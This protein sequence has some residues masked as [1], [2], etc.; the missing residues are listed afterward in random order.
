MAPVKF[1]IRLP[2]IDIFPEDLMKIAKVLTGDENAVV[3]GVRDLGNGINR[4]IIEDLARHFLDINSITGKIDHYVLDD[5]G[6]L[7][8]IGEHTEGDIATI[9]GRDLG[10]GLA[11]IGNFL[12]SG[13]LLATLSGL[14]IG[15][16]V[17]GGLVSQGSSPSGSST[18]SS[19]SSTQTTSAGSASLG[20]LGSVNVVCGQGTVNGYPAVIEI[21]GTTYYAYGTTPAG[22]AQ[23]AGIQYVAEGA[24]PMGVAG[25]P[26]PSDPNKVYFINPDGSVQTFGLGVGQQIIATAQQQCSGAVAQGQMNAGNVLQ[27]QLQTLSA[28]MPSVPSST[29]SSTGQAVSASVAPEVAPETSVPSNTPASQ[30]T[31][32]VGSSIFSNKT[33]LIGIAV[34]MVIIIIAM[35]V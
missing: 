7:I 8:K 32:T 9:L 28:S 5:F 31:S 34:I 16:S 18:A 29:P 20:G 4:V 11:K 14:G 15:L 30:P 1:P 6:N 21:N 35:V 25:N 27:S 17:A 2:H 22:G 13:K 24:T 23:G 10:G 12:R 3:K 19:G 33:V 26:F